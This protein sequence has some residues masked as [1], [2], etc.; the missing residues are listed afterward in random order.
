MEVAVLLGF[1]AVPIAFLVTRKSY[2]PNIGINPQAKGWRR[3]PYVVGF[4]VGPVIVMAGILFLIAAPI[5][6]D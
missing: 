1:L 4:V 6:G 3:I 5:W 2:A